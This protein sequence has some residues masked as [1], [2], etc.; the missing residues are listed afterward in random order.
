[1]TI[2]KYTE[3]YDSGL[4]W[5]G[6]VP[7]HWSLK[8]LGHFFSE[9]REKVSDKEFQPLSVTKHGIVPRL[10]TAAKTQDGDNRKR[11]I[12]GDFVINSRSD[13][14]GSSGLSELDGS[15]SL[16]CIVLEPDGVYGRFAHHLLR[17]EVFQE[18]FYRNGKGIVADLWST[19]FSEMKNIVIPV[20][21]QHEQT[22]IARFLDHETAKID[23]LIREQERLIDLLQ[24]KRQAV[25]SHAVTKGLD[26]DVPMKDSGVKWLGEVPAHWHVARLKHL[27]RTKGGSTPSKENQE[28]WEGEIPWVSPKDMKKSRISDSSDHIS[29]K[30]LLETGLS[31]IKSQSVLIVVRGMILAHSVPVAITEVPVTI[32]QDMKAL[33]AGPNVNPDYLL[34]LLSGIRDAVFEYI[35][36]SAHGTKKL[37]WERFEGIQLPVPRLGEQRHSVLEVEKRLKQIDELSRQAVGVNRL[38]QERR[39]GLISAAVTGKI[40]VRGWQPPKDESA[41]DEDIHQAGLETTA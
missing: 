34:L 30:A 19:G 1:M 31:S 27:V 7:K 41:F 16:I 28:Y 22:Q 20:P 24:E 39:S 14:K 32:N 37:E 17:S 4:A 10:E 15:V 40:D 29:E 38:L 12:A 23:A 26:P 18:E 33:E 2:A 21:S 5:L 25:I 9:R 3:N 36:S 11:V 6:A 13:R 35:D 8:R